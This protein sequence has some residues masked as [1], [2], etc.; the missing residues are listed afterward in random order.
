MENNKK[1]QFITRKTNLD[2][3]HRVMNERMKCFML[4]GHTY[5]TELMFS[6]E[7]IEEIG[8][9]IDFKEIKRVFIQFLQDK[10]DHGM[11]LN[12]QDHE[13]IETI[14]KLNSKLWLMSLNGKDEYCNPTVENITKEVFISMMVISHVLYGNSP[15][16]LKI[17][18]VR[19]YETPN[20]WSDCYQDSISELEMRNFT[21]FRFEEIKQYSLN[22]GI[23][24]YDERKT[25]S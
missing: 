21:E 18:R 23:I 19:M 16:G 11:L 22:K 17:H 9:A 10:M 3:G 14:K 13:I 5:L 25:I 4:H 12:P 20:C 8:Y 15:T 7:N 1:L 2:C 6:F 24:E